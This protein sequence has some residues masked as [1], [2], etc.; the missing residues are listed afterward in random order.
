MPSI[1]KTQLR[2]WRRRVKT[3]DTKARDL[4]DE[5]AKLTGMDGDPTDYV[6]NIL[7]GTEDL[8]SVLAKPDLDMWKI[9]EPGTDVT[10][11]ERT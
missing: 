2:A 11:G 7:H 3:L 6:D 8:L 9:A 1:S 10:N 4:M 5:M